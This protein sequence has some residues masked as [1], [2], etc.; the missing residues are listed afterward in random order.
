MRSASHAD[1][2]SL[3][4]WNQPCHLVHS[5]TLNDQVDTYC[6]PPHPGDDISIPQV[7]PYEIPLWEMSRERGGQEEYGAPGE[8]S[9]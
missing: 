3:T 5:Q 8:M 2:A 1:P 7:T 9:S 6:T 4:F